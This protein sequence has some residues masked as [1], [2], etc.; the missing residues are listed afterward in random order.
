MRHRREQQQ[1]TLAAIAEQTKIKAS[2]L[3]GLERDDISSWPVGIFRRAFIRAYAQAIGLDPGVVL[4]EFLTVYPDP[5]DDAFTP[6][7]DAVADGARPAARPP[8]RLRFLVGSALGSLSRGRPDSIL[9]PAGAVDRP[10]ER[11]PVAAIPPPLVDPAAAQSPVEPDIAAVA[12]LCT[13]LSRVDQ[14]SEMAPLLAEAARIL[15]AS[16]LIIWVWHAQT[17]HLRPVLAHGYPDSLLAQLPPVKRGSDNATAAAFRSAQPCVVEGSDHV[18]GA[19]VVPLMTPGGCGGVLALE[20]PGGR[21]QIVL[22]RSVVAILAAQLA[23]WIRA[24]RQ[25]E[26]PDRR[27]A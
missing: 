22:V 26:I 2:H 6:P 10:E 27:L 12:Q 23:R 1:I 8:T 3:E 7:A 25:G 9:P 13:E 5:V 4:Q 24:E 17:G 15:N 19:L 20:L 21:E 18:N 14:R 11:E 16:G